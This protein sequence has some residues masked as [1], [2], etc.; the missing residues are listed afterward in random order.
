MFH[1]NPESTPSWGGD[2]V[3]VRVL[4]PALLHDRM[5]PLPFVV[6]HVDAQ[7]QPAQLRPVLFTR[8]QEGSVG[9]NTRTETAGTPSGPGAMGIKGLRAVPR[10]TGPAGTEQRQ[11]LARGNPRAPGHSRKRGAR[12]VGRG[13]T[14]HKCR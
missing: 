13:R 6:G 2:L 11:R 5:Q 3:H 7:L 14:L 8:L 12:D 1:A 10:S 9:S 4:Q